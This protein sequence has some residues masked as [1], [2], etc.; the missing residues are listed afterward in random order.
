VF[1]T[2]SSASEVSSR[3]VPRFLLRNRMSATQHLRIAFLVSMAVGVW[4]FAGCC[5]ARRAA[6]PADSEAEVITAI[7]G[8]F[9]TNLYPVFQPGHPLIVLDQTQIW[10][11][12]VLGANVDNLRRQLPKVF[13]ML[14]RL[15]AA[16]RVAHALPSRVETG[17]FLRFSA[18]RFSEL[19][20]VSPGEDEPV[21]SELDALKKILGGPPFVVSFSLPVVDEAAGRA[22]VAVHANDM[23]QKWSFSR[24]TELYGLERR[25]QQWIVTGRFSVLIW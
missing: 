17:P 10:Y 6:L 13:D 4:A 5:S 22:L 14:P 18:K 23:A 7:L 1:A 21:P 20:K 11:P 3:S 24:E 9:Q 2:P 15:E 16:N 25:G 12:E 19:C 8:R